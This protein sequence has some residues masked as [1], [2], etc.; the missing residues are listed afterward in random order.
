MGSKGYKGNKIKNC[1]MA[2]RL[3]D[4]GK[5]KKD[6][7]KKLPLEYKLLWLYILDDCDHAGI[8]DVDIEVA[9][10]RLGTKFSLEKARGYFNINMV[11]LEN[12]TKW[13]VPDF[14]QF[15]YGHFNESNKMFKSIMPIINKYNLKGVLRGIEGGSE[16][17]Q[18]T[19]TVK[20]EVT[21]KQEVTNNEGVAVKKAIGSELVK[22]CAREAWDD[23]A[24]REAI[25]M[26]K[27]LTD[28]ELKQWMASFNASVSNDCIENFNSNTYRKLF[29]G[30]LD[31]QR[32]KGR[33]LKQP[34]KSY[35]P[36][37]V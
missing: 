1:L 24:W 18:V 15:Q 33:E 12:G 34:E 9:E 28:A 17:V 13:F 30:W 31:V 19:V 20:E 23:K 37:L 32:Q 5:W 14:I 3:T 16:G 4:T 10:L 26:A 22:S 8:W 35:T 27:T 25:C 7:F 36:R 21:N 6:W 29:G 11:V 2:K